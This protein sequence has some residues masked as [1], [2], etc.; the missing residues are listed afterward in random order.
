MSLKRFIQNALSE[1]MKGKGPENDIV[2]STR[3]RLARNLKSYPFPI[4]A[5]TEMKEHV[6]HEIMDAV[7]SSR[8]KERLGTLETLKMNSLSPLERRVLVE[9]HLISP[10][11]ANESE[12]GA[13]VLSEH[14]EISIMVNEEDHLRIQCMLPGLQMEQAWEVANLL[15]NLLEQELDYAFDEKYGYQ[16]SCP[17]N[18]GTGIRVSVMLHLPALVITNQIN[19]IL[20]TINQVGLVA[21]GIYGEGSEAQ[22]NLFQISNQLTLGL[23]EEEIINNLHS[24]ALQLI[25]QERTA[26][27][28]LIEHNRIAL[29]DKVFRSFGVLLYSRILE[30]KEATERLS[31][32]RLGIDLGLIKDTSPTI[33]NELM[34]MTQPGFIQQYY[35]QSLTPDER[36][37]RRAKMVRD[38]L[39]NQG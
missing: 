13:V 18:M 10:Q 2:I 26:R 21:R 37:E 35:Q 20:A 5:S 34:V 23:S 7:Q 32:V 25:N 29:E 28:L 36:D 12:E 38:H 39:N 6:L 15:D 33:L 17:T 9:K 19:R 22:G 11:L 31:D 16:T 3:I 30:S 1:W 14:E 27:N 8:I 24:V 4:M